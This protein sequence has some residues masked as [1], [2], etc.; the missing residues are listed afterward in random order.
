MSTYMWM[1][2]KCT[3]EWFSDVKK[4][5]NT[6]QII[7]QIKNNLLILFCYYFCFVNILMVKK[8]NKGTKRTSFFS[9]RG[10][11]LILKSMGPFIE[12]F[13]IITVNVQF[14]V[15]P[16]NILQANRY[17]CVAFHNVVS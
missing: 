13:K 4:E 15:F 5:L 3:F 2:S 14:I 6:E 11:A 16:H 10:E 12:N 1:S 7:L 9:L 17:A 8:N